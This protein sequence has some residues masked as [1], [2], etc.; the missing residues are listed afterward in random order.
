MGLAQFFMKL[1]NLAI[2]QGYEPASIAA[3]SSKFLQDGVV[4]G[5]LI[6]G[7]KQL[8]L[9]INDGIGIK[10]LKEVLAKKAKQDVEI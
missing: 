3:E 4:T 2:K 5:K 1:R 7:R 9:P 8:H 6:G 10:D